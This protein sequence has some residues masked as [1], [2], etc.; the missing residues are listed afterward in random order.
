MIT[1]DARLNLCDRELL[2]Y[3]YV[4]SPVR[5]AS[6]RAFQIF[7]EGAIIP[8]HQTIH[9]DV[10]DKPA[11]GVSFPTGRVLVNGPVWTLTEKG[12]YL[13]L[14]I[15]S[16][17]QEGAAMEAILAPM[18]RK[19]K[20]FVSIPWV[21]Q[22]SFVS[23]WNLLFQVIFRVSLDLQKEQLVRGLGLMVSQKGFLVNAAPHEDSRKILNSV[24][25]RFPSLGEDRL[26]LRTEKDGVYLYATP[27]TR[28]LSGSRSANTRLQKLV[29]FHPVIAD[30]QEGL[31]GPVQLSRSELLSHFGQSGVENISSSAKLPALTPLDE[32]SAH[33]L[34]VESA[35][36]LASELERIA[37]TP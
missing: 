5:Y 28:S 34:R 13:F 10:I 33:S 32:F 37:T 20:I 3:F 19:V 26:L 2:F 12:D 7:G 31:D 27:W 29:F 6:L 18:R 4:K 15:S 8:T 23:A 21:A 17:L 14:R 25:K 22:K 1:A 11:E 36:H 35:D 30:A 16:P 9:V 24:A